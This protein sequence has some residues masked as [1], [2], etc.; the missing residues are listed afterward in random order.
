MN[1]RM[2]GLFLALL[3]L[4]SLSGCGALRAWQMIQDQGNVEETPESDNSLTP[5]VTGRRPSSPAPS[6]GNE[7]PDHP[8]EGWSSEPQDPSLGMLRQEIRQSGNTVGL[9]FINY[10]DYSSSEVDLRDYLMYS[11][12]GQAY[13]FLTESSLLM[14][15][16]QEFYAIV[17]ASETSTIT[18]YASDAPQAEY[19]DDFSQ[20][21]SE[22]LPGEPLLLFCNF[23]E[24]YSNVLI[25]VSDG[26]EILDFRPSL[27]MEDGH[28]AEVSGVYDFS[29][30]QGEPSES[31]VQ[32]AMERLM[33]FDEIQAAL[34]QGMSL[35]YTGETQYVDGFYCLIFALSIDNGDQFITKSYYFV[36]NNYIYSYDIMNDA[37]FLL[38]MG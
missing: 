31:E 17:P 1:K 24:I 2:I 14:V 30:Y 10:M 15:Q 34:Q 27:S 25:R 3:L 26:D 11:D 23:S 38:G 32:F 6:S 19:V 35:T 20:P 22:S 29:I 9:A 36:S 8:D 13:P 16:G 28:I 18:V 7:V 12:I 37:W 21:L 5:P 33:E 4:V